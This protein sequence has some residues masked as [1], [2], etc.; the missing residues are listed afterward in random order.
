M[1]EV[2][3]MFDVNP[4]L[5]RFW[6]SKFSILK[7][8]KNKKGNRLFTPEDVD[9]LNLIY[10]LV[11]EKGMTLAGAQKRIR[12]N[13]EGE[14][15]DMEI[16]D[17]LMKIRSLLMEIRQELKEG[18]SDLDDEDMSEENYEDTAQILSKLTDEAVKD[19]A[20]G[21]REGRAVCAE[22]DSEYASSENSVEVS[23]AEGV[24][25]VPM[26]ENQVA[27]SEDGD[28]GQGEHTEFNTVE[29]EADD[30]EVASAESLIN[31][32]T[33]H[34]DEGCGGSEPKNNSGQVDPAE[35]VMSELLVNELTDSADEACGGEH[36]N[37]A[38]DSD[39][40]DP[41]ADKFLTTEALFNH[42]TDKADEYCGDMHGTA[43]VG[44]E[45]YGEI[46]VIDTREDIKYFS[47]EDEDS[48][49]EPGTEPEDYFSPEEYETAEDEESAQE[50]AGEERSRPYAVEQTLF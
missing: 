34:D 31:V 29:E 36:R 3:E 38:V 18:R 14:K 19:C 41:G 5:I 33:D 48:E 43:E 15:R 21:D 28:D 24:V 42:I 9:N 22:S 32:L 45:Y 11:K 10:H 17:R 8:H 47:G 20:A 1:G 12:D 37:T 13:K 26:F 50:N 35:A 27:E 39:A 25:P 49:F 40:D 46:T 23:P 6:E 4:S 44:D 2:C 16:V 30:E 7:P